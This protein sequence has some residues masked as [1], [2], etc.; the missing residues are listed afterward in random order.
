M[1]FP[2]VVL[3]PGDVYSEG[4]DNIVEEGDGAVS[5]WRGEY[6]SVGDVEFVNWLSGWG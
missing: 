4:V 1:I 3:I 2:W 5:E 6:L